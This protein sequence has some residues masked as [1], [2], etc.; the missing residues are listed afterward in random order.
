[1]KDW[2][3]VADEEEDAIEDQQ[4]M[5]K[6]NFKNREQTADESVD[7]YSYLKGAIEKN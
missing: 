3:D 6:E 1:M 5:A 7:N 4:H 2:N